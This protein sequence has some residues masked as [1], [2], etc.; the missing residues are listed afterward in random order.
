MIYEGVGVFAGYFGRDDLTAQ[1][2]IDI[3]GEKCYRTGDFGRLDVKS[4]QLVFTGRKDFQV[5]LRG[6]RI[7]LSSIESVILEGSSNVVNCVVMKDGSDSD[8]YLSA[9]LKMKENPEKDNVRDE[10]IRI[11]K[12]QLPSYMVPS[13]WFLIVD[14]PLNANGKIDRSKLSE[15]AES[16]ESERRSEPVRI[17]SSLERRLEDIFIRTFRLNVCPDVEMS[18]GQLGGTSLGA[19][20]AL[21][22][23]RQEVFEKM[24]ISLLFANPSIRQLAAALEPLLVNVETVEE[25]ED[26][27]KDFSIRPRSSWVIETLGI[28]LL[29]WQ[30]LWPIY[31]AS[32]LQFHFLQVLFVP[33]VH[34][35]QYPIFMRLL[36]GPFPRGRDR[37][38]SLRYYG[39]WFLRR[40]WSLNSY[41]LNH[42]LGTPFYNAYLRL[43]GARIGDDVHIYT[44][45]IDAP[46]LIDVGN[47]TFIGQEVVL[48]S[49]TYH[50]CIYDLSEIHIGSNCSIETRCV[51]HDR[52]DIHDGVFIEPLTAVTG[53]ILGNNVERKLSCNSIGGQ[54]MIQLIAILA[55]VGIHTFIVKL[56]W[57]LVSCLP[58]YLI[59]PVCWLIWSIVGACLSLL[60]LRFVVSNV[61]QNFSHSLNSWQF[62]R[63]FWL[64]H[65]VVRSFG[66]CLSTVFDGLNSLT[67]S[68]LRWLGAEIEMNNI[69]IADFVPLLEVPSNLLIIKSDV[70]MTSEICFVPYD[71]TIDGQ[72]VVTG[73][74]QINRGSFLGN[75]CILRSGVSVPEDSLIGSLTRVDSTTIITNENNGLDNILFGVPARSMPFILSD[76]DSLQD[77][78]ISKQH[79]IPKIIENF[80]Q[81]LLEFAHFVLLSI[82]VV[83]SMRITSNFSQFVLLVP[84]FLFIYSFIISVIYTRLIGNNLDQINVNW[85]I[86]LAMGLFD[87]YTKYVGN[88]VGGTQ[89]LIIILRQ[90]GAHISND[91]IIDDIN[92]LYDVHL[93][94][95]GSHTRLSSTC[96]IQ[97]SSIVNYLLIFVS[98]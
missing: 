73:P 28:L 26:D 53:R 88:L 44:N 41:W 39:I 75:N 96:Q 40:Q 85:H 11:C 6:Q 29:T 3:D 16:I 98:L 72:C 22:T 18:F 23:I 4:G 56:C 67:P 57:L 97:V 55:M 64:R 92:S 43:C 38:Y 62:L 12:R 32:Q 25:K 94:T 60:L 47:S 68:I 86:T 17:L 84:T 30:W 76:A 51:L 14:F 33:S 13:K 9:Y 2:L 19:M 91:V 63:G 48:S 70:T 80:Q 49:L 83:L 87:R 46:W 74:I 20:H 50:D 61:E 65:L 78:A 27:D 15:V 58:V 79:I 42:L 35:L 95:I 5:K 89:W 1:V 71:V 66:P 24:D 69:E 37:L 81:I 36:G 54:S 82:C 77:T 21:I 45:E 31:L 10:M 59:L 52:V 7:E 90:F 34:L 8:S 93:I